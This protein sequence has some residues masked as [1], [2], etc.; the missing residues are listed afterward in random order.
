MHRAVALRRVHLLNRRAFGS[1]GSVFCGDVLLVKFVDAGCGKRIVQFRFVQLPLERCLLG[2]EGISVRLEWLHRRRFE[3]VAATL[4]LAGLLLASP[5]GGAPAAT[6]AVPT[7]FQETTAFSGLANPTVVRFASDGRVFVVEK[8]GLIKVFFQISGTWLASGIRRSPH[9]RPQLLGSRPPG[10]GARSELP[11]VESLRLRPLRVQPRAPNLE[12]LRR[13]GQAGL[14]ARRQAAG[15]DLADGC[16]VSGRPVPPAGGG[17]RD[18]RQRAGPGSRTGASSTRAT[19]SGT[20]RS[21]PTV[22]CI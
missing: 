8:S 15:S 21:A 3:A 7:G 4:L 18:D 19:R 5:V 16:V 20:S 13:A 12:L 1:A 17:R 10:D 2:E 22:R 14:R 6:V 11:G 9:Q